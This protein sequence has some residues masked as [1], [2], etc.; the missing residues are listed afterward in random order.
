MAILIHIQATRQNVAPFTDLSLI[1]KDIFPL[2]WMYA[3]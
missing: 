3:A 1:F 2:Q